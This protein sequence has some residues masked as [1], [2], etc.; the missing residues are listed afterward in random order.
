MVS[1]VSMN[2][3]GNERK[4]PLERSKS[5]YVY[6][7]LY[8]RR[9]GV[10]ARR[11]RLYKPAP[12]RG[13]LFLCL[14]QGHK[15][16]KTHRKG[17]RTPPLPAPPPPPLPQSAATLKRLSRR[18]TEHRRL[19]HQESA[20]DPRRLSRQVSEHRRLTPQDSAAAPERLGGRGIHR[21]LPGSLG[22]L[23]F[24]GLLGHPLCA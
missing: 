20:A 13:G 4:S 17:V 18:S 2:T 3:R 10:S 8:A 11:M 9:Q 15:A 5:R 23:G 1:L 24:L 22:R 16:Q 7:S 21:H 6:A 19:T 12:H 14:A